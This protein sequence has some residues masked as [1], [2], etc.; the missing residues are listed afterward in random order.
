MLLLCDRWQQRGSLTEWCLTWKCVWSK[1]VSL[2]SPMQKRLHHWYSSLLAECLWRPNS[3]RQH[4]ELMGSTFQQWPQWI[5]STCPDFYEHGMQAPV[6]HWQECIY[7]GGDYVGKRV[8]CSWEFA[9]SNS[10]IVLFVSVV[11]SMKIN[12]R[13]YFWS[14]LCILCQRSPLITTDE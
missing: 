14:N 10:A 5:T 11:F 3:G 12:W 2:N 8:F 13:H 4:S 1:Y 6:Y 9:L 7:N